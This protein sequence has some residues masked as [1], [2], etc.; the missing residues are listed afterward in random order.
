MAHVV[1]LPAEPFFTADGALEV[2]QI[3]LGDDN[4]GWLLVCTKTRL[5]AIVDGPADAQPYL[6]RCAERGVTL[7]A[8]LNTHTHMDHIGV[9]LDL[10][11]RGLLAG[12]RVIGCEAT[13]DAIPGLTEVVREGSPVRIGEAVGATWLTEGH[14]RGHVSYVFGDA[15]F[16]GDTMF[17]G[18]CGRLMDGMPDTM[19]QSLLRLAT[20]PDGTRV[21][22]AHEYTQDNLRFAWTVESDNEALAHRI[23]RVWSL[24]EHGRSA[25]PSRIEEE[26]ATN[27][28]LRVGSPTLLHILSRVAPEADLDRAEVVFATL[29][30]LKD[31]GRYRK[32]TDDQLPL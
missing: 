32:L 18:G 30:E 3:P 13:A 17:T 23:E 28:F 14:L 21:C 11:R 25:V 4:L 6:D 10:Q 15:V 16:C 9:N 22:C 8:V 19:L 2:H 7:H 26:R 27:P 29:R 24:R 5:G 20:L 12:L 31:S 1:T